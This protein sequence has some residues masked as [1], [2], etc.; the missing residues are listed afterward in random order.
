MTT[1]PSEPTG[2][3]PAE[4]AESAAGGPAVPGG[5]YPDPSAFED[6]DSIDSAAIV[7]DPDGYQPP[8]DPDAEP[9]DQPG[10]DEPGEDA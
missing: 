5:D 9:A 3:A 8:A 7:E 10:D 6:G 2:T 4:A 1:Q